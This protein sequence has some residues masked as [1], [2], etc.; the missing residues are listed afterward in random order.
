ML[1]L[2]TGEFY[3]IIAEPFVLF[4]NNGGSDSDKH[5]PPGKVTGNYIKLDF[6][7]VFFMIT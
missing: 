4:S 1:K 5:K 2:L 3:L 6:F 7:L